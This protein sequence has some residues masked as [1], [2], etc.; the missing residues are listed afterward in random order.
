MVAESVALIIER[1]T[2]SLSVA[3]LCRELADSGGVRRTGLHHSHLSI[4]SLLL[5]DGGAIDDSELLVDHSQ[6]IV[7]FG[8]SGN[9]FGTR[10]L[11]EV[12]RILEESLS[13]A[14]LGGITSKDVELPIESDRDSEAFALPSGAGAVDLSVDIEAERGE[15]AEFGG[16]E[17]GLHLKD[18]EVSLADIGIVSESLLDKILE[19]WVGEERAPGEASDTIVERLLLKSR[20]A[21]IGS[22]LILLIDTAAVEAAE[23]ER[24]NEKLFH[25]ERIKLRYKAGSKAGRVRCGDPAVKS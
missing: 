25:N 7:S 17:R 14:D 8:D 20:G 22:R 10:S 4:K 13:L 23:R 3:E 12:A 19:L 24:N 9:K 2:L 11:F 15:I 6:R 18:R 21:G 5:N 1:G 16:S